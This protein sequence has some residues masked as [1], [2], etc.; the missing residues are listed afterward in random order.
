[1]KF[2]LN[3][4]ERDLPKHSNLLALKYIYKYAPFVVTGKFGIDF[5]NSSIFKA[6]SLTVSKDLRLG[7]AL[8]LNLRATF[9]NMWGRNILKNDLFFRNLDTWPGDRT[10]NFISPRVELRFTQFPFLSYFK[11]NPHL[12]TKLFVSFREGPGQRR[13]AKY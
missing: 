1:M 13:D 10:K 7:D 5:G 12:Y 6:I 9:A 11:F 2:G 8:L 3:Q 4:P